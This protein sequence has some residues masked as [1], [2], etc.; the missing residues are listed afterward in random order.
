MAHPSRHA[1]TLL[2]ALVHERLRHLSVD[3][4]RSISDLLVDGA[5]MLLRWHGYSEGLPA[6]EPPPS[7]DDKSGG[8]Q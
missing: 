1:R 3:L 5:V 8:S 4:D 2:P 6:P 7:S